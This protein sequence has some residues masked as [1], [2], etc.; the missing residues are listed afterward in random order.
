M[1]SLV[2]FRQD[3]RLADNPALAAAFARGADVILA[4]ILDEETPGVR[5]LG[6]A[7]RWWLHGSLDSLA[8]DIDRRGGRLIL[9][10]GPATRE[11][12]RLI[13]EGK[14]EAVYW[15]RCH[16]P[17]LVKRDE[18]I[19]ARLK[20]RGL[21]VESFNASLLHEPW[22]VKTKGGK[23]FQVFTPFWKALKELPAPAH[24]HRTPQDL[25]GGAKLRSDVLADWDLLPRRPDWAGG[26]RAAW[27]PG[28]AGAHRRV[29]AF[30]DRIASYHV[31]R[32]RPAIEGTSLLSPHLHWGEIGPWQVWRAAEHSAGGPGEA[33]PF[34]RE[35][36]WREFCG[37]LLFH[38]PALPDQCLRAEFQN[39]PWA[40]QEILLDAW[41]RGRTGYPLID[42]GMRQLWHT[43]WMHNRVRM[44]VASFLVKHLLHHW[45]DGEAWFWDTL[46]D[47]DLASNVANWQWVAGCGA[48][49]APF[50]RIF[51]PILQGEKF[52]P[53]GGYVRHWLPEL[54]HL[55]DKWLHHPWDAPSDV[56][57][58]AKVTLG[59]TYPKPVVDHGTA[60]NH[61]LE[62]FRS[63]RE[64]A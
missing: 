33:E 16:Q 56:L 1:T 6:G 22:E 57:R 8:R 3:L 54:A 20:E 59:E 23:P 48:D 11:L 41:Q 39:F 52:D 7:A 43:G 12:D 60:R 10:R 49:A 30:G 4:F 45:R 42:A 61:A 18:R 46:V 2:W 64:P 35:L 21:T 34:L 38:E 15:N 50:F 31:A 19:K 37:S 32:D 36:G 44:V 27:Q 62:A 55:P 14:V 63:L 26:L 58:A 53:R 9:R 24:V 17:A 51:N 47:A 40:R 5:P 25:A 28:E 29:E 13:E